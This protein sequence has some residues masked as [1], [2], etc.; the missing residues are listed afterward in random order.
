M[1]NPEDSA[2]QAE[3][4]ALH[5]LD[6]AVGAAVARMRSLR[7]R[8]EEAASRARDA[9]E[10]LRRFTGDPEEATRLLGRMRALEAENADLR[11]RLAR[12]R[13]GVERML[14]RLRF[15]EEQR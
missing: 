1:S 10:I 2:A 9:Q 14:A 7:V 13:E 11:Q 3:H 4:A 5:E 6:R 12:G 15:L 8:A